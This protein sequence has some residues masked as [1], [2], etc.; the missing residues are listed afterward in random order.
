MKVLTPEPVPSSSGSPASEPRGSG[1]F[2]GYA[3]IRSGRAR[4]R[5]PT[6][7]APAQRRGPTSPQMADTGRVILRALK[8]AS[9]W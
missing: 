8:D 4:P 3:V 1:S 7:T 6:S 2:A 5:L 9:R